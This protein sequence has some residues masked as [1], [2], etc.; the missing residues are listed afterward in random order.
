MMEKSFIFFSLPR[1]RCGKDIIL[2]LFFFISVICSISSAAESKKVYKAGLPHVRG[3]MY[4]NADGSPGGFPCE[5][6][7][8]AARDEGIKL[9]WVDGAWTELFDKLKNGEIDVLPGVQISKERRAFLDYLDYNLYSAWTEAYMKNGKTIKSLIDLADS[10]VA[11]VYKDNNAA[12]FL[13]SMKKIKLRINPVWFNSHEEAFDALLEDKVY[14][15]ISPSI[16]DV[17]NFNSNIKGSGLFV[18]PNNSSIAFLKGKNSELRLALNNRMGKYKVNP[19]SIYNKLFKKYGLCHIMHKDSFIPEWLI[20]TFY[21]VVVAVL[22]AVI[23]IVILRH[24]VN[25]RTEALEVSRYNYRLL[26]RNMTVGFASYK[27]IYGDNGKPLDYKFM[28]V[29]PAFEKLTGL[30]ARQLVGN[31]VKEV[32]PEIEYHWVERFAKVV[33]TGEAEFYED[34]NRK[35]DRYFD[36]WAFPTVRKSFGVL[37]TDISEQKRMEQRQILFNKVLALLNSDYNIAGIINELADLFKDFSKADSVGIR[38]REEKIFPYYVTRG[39]LH[40]TNSKADSLCIPKNN[41]KISRNNEGQLVFECL[42]CSVISS[43]IRNEEC[44]FTS[45]GSFWINNVSKQDDVAVLCKGG[46]DKC[47]LSGYES[48]ALIPLKKDNKAVGMIQ[49]SYYEPDKLSLE[50]IEFFE[51]IGQSIG[52]AL[53]RINNHIQLDESRKKAEAANQAKSEFLSTMS[54]EIRTPLNGIIGFSEI[55]KDMLYESVN[56]KNRDKMIEYLELVGK[57]GSSLTEIIGDILEIS[58]IEAKHF[59]IIIENFDPQALISKSMDIFMMKAEEN[60]VSLNFYPENLPHVV[61]GAAKRLKQL[62]FNLVGN[63]VK[64]TRN[65]NVDINATCR[66]ENLLVE[67]KDTGIGIPADMIDKILEPF[68]QADQS[69]TRSHEGTGLGLAIVSRILENLG[70]SLD[71]KS[72]LGKGSTF[73]FVFP[74]KVVDE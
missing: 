42:C 68:S 66:G 14:A 43:D 1:L 21:A 27:M 34:Y 33:R 71:I 44:H 28:Q 15:V 56:F 4:R 67:V 22:I 30:T 20:Y 54:H 51:K 70:G 53:E 74:V 59:P 63:A 60:N 24:Q 23:F 26:F 73:S 61:S 17:K 18:N 50:L 13:K 41:G 16:I 39:D 57:C 31:T 19:G 36:I 72:E 38:V 65:G 69:N 3:I 46:Y 6:L 62:I 11:L 25:S 5:I 2:I 47:C 10:N 8:H 32:F 45:K 9:Q 48:L 7:D 55:V 49:L 40:N 58:S 64:F 52:I 37:V 29:N 35:Q 12:A